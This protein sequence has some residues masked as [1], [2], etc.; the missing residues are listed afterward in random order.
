MTPLDTSPAASDLQTKIIRN[1]TASER[2]KSALELSDLT[3]KLA[4]AR[5]ELEHPGI[6]KEELVRKFLQVILDREQYL[7]ILK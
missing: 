1:M 3:R 2:L 4:F 7:A 5:L 6:S